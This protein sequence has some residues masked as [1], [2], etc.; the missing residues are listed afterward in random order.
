MRGGTPIAPDRRIFI[1]RRPG[2]AG[3]FAESGR[4]W[5]R[6]FQ[7]SD[8]EERRLHRWRTHANGQKR[9]KQNRGRNRRCAWRILTIAGCEKRGTAVVRHVGR[10]RMNTGMQLR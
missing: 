8:D 10:V 7:S 1:K 9:G 2:E 3:R 6:V 4:D 5:R